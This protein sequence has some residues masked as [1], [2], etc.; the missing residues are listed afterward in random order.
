MVNK[1]ADVNVKDTY[2]QTPLHLAASKGQI[3]V[4][5]CLIENGANVNVTQE[6]TGSTP[7][8]RAASNGQVEVV[9]CL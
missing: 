6:T 8:H 7:L 4:I 9:K 5:R 1:G 3:K 2:G